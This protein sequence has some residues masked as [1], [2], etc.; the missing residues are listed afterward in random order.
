MLSERL[1]G[2]PRQTKKRLKILAPPHPPDRMSMLEPEPP[3]TTADRIAT[4][5]A[6]DFLA[7][8]VADEG[9]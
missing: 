7:G 6:I 9:A 5:L 1:L 2:I 8:V 4:R 3:V